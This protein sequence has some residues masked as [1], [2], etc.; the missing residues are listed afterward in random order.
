MY[1]YSGIDYHSVLRS[2]AEKHQQYC[3]SCI[4]TD[5]SA[6]SLYNI[7]L[8]EQP[9]IRPSLHFIFNYPGVPTTILS[10]P[11]GSELMNHYLL[12]RTDSITQLYTAIKQDRPRIRCYNW[13]QARQHLTDLLNMRR[14]PTE[15]ESGATKF[16]YRRHGSKADDGLHS[17]NYAYIVARMM[18]NEPMCQDR[19]TQNEI[20]NVLR[21]A[22]ARTTGARVGGVISG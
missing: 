19:G 7:L 22:F 15:T 13:A 21:S 14:V 5:F 16:R 2:I 3:G 18:L 12:N 1:R 4:G 10:K 8:R 17:L 20:A 6:G 9:G 11:A